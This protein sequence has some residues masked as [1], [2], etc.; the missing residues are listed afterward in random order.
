MRGRGASTV[1]TSPSWSSRS[2]LPRRFGAA[3]SVPLPPKNIRSQRVDAIEEQHAVEVVDL[4]EEAARLERV[5]LDG[6]GLAGRVGRLDGDG[7][8]PAHIRGQV[9]DR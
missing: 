3:T 5:R 7:R 9:G 8:G 1:A 4:V 6:H 2:G